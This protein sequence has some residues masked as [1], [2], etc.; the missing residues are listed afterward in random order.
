[1]IY[2]K[3]IL[4][5]ISSQSLSYSWH[6]APWN[7][8]SI[9]SP[10]CWEGLGAGGEGDDRGWDDWIASPTWWT[11][12]WVNSGRW[13][14]TGRPDVLQF[15]GSQ[16]VG[17]NWVTELNWREEFIF[18]CP[19]LLPFHTAHGVLKA[20]ILKWFSIPI[21]SGPHFSRTLHHDLSILGGLTGHN[22]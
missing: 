14:W 16:R 10:W 18:T 6:R 9:E 13:W 2:K 12:V 11:R 19:I 22:S 3:Y 1:M 5:Y 4:M 7:F 15:M 17:H 8:L 21:S 20:R